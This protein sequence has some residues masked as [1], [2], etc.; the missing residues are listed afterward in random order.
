MDRVNDLILL[1]LLAVDE[2]FKLAR[3]DSDVPLII[4]HLGTGSVLDTTLRVNR[5]LTWCLL[6]PKLKCFQNL[7]R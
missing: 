2:Q 5:T 4:L 7:A 1:L 3:L 6:L